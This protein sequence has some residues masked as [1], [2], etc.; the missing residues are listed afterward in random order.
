M[1][2][3]KSKTGTWITLQGTLIEVQIALS[4]ERVQPHQIGAITQKSDSTEFTAFY[5]RGK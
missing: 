4:N 3:T 5:Y 1:T 2:V